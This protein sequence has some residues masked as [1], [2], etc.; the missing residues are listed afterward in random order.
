MPM[1]TALALLAGPALAADR[2]D[3]GREIL[4]R[5]PEW[6]GVQ[7]T[8]PIDVYEEYVRFLMRGPVPPQ[9]P[10]VVWIERAAYR[11]HP[12]EKEAEVEAA[13]DVVRLPGDGPRSVRL[14]PADLAWREATLDGAKTELRR[15]DGGWFCIDTAGPGRYRVAAR[16]ALKPAMAGDVYRIEF[17]APPAGWATLE[18][19]SPEAWDV[20]SPRSPLAIVG[21]A[22]GTRGTAGLAA[23]DRLDVTWRRPQPPVHRAA[24]IAVE[25]Q[26]GW[27]L[28]DGVHQVRA[29][30]DLHLWGGEASELSLTLPP[31]ADRVAI[32]G[33][34]VREVQVQGTQARVFLR[35]AIAQRTRLS[36]S[37]ESPRSATGLMSL[38]AFG[39]EGATPRGGTLAIAGGAGGVLLEMDSPG[40]APM[41]LADLS[42]ETRALLA[43]PPV[44]AYAL[45]G[46]WEAQVDLVGM[47]E[48]P[49]RETLVDSAL[50]TVVY[51]PSGEVMTK[52]I[53]EVRN[54]AQQ[55]MA[56]DLPPGSRL[57][58]ARV[59]ERQRNLARGEGNAVY[60]PLEK[61]VLT[62]AGLVSFPVE[63]VYVM[64]A[65]AL[66][67]K[68]RFR[69]P[70]PR[71]DLPVAY[72]RCALMLP[73][74]M[75]ADEWSGTLRRTDAWSGETADI[76]FEYGTG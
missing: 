36:V 51:R 59:A 47:S 6:P 30:L 22:A 50:Y 76:E 75:K 72:A 2:G 17:A 68:G 16:A 52:V 53:Y 35:G 55:Y 28:A 41:A 32:T 69:L 13:M 7:V 63:L 38:P 12:G 23:G 34:D 29:A 71:T 37:F 48:F 19:D 58:V 25:S 3:L 15:D 39:V 40:L 60:V 14:L 64:R 27:T 46:R 70:L 49:V 4:R 54:R 20:R 67:R 65:E 24:Q 5:V 8:I 9:P 11:L 56:V 45:S 21:T 1:L 62:T 61:S 31:G 43:G 66:G 73:D 44:Y 57:I 74:G 33:P 18:V 10:Q 26:V 42:D